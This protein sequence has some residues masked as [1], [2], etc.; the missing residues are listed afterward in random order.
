MM[1]NGPAAAYGDIFGDS[2]DRG[3]KSVGYSHG[4][5]GRCAV[6]YE[7][8]DLFHRVD[9]DYVASCRPNRLLCDDSVLD[10]YKTL[11][12]WITPARS[13]LPFWNGR[14]PLCG[15]FAYR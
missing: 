5:D 6:Q 14:R 1:E 11:T 2:S 12:W 15:G 7:G 10:E 3:S 8:K 13:A 4:N 9:S